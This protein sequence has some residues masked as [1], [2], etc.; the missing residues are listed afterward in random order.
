MSVSHSGTAGRD[1]ERADLHKFCCVD[2]L[3][4]VCISVLYLVSVTVSCTF[5]VL[6]FHLDGI[7]YLLLFTIEV[8]K[9]SA[10]G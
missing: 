5:L 3:V 4:L 9:K 8:F 2:D 10:A 7:F 1:A 6:V